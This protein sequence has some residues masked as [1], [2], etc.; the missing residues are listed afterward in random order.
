M[1]LLFHFS[2]GRDTG[3]FLP[4][5]LGQSKP[6]DHN[7]YKGVGKDDAI[8]CPGTNPGAVMDN[9]NDYHPSL[10]LTFEEGLVFYNDSWKCPSL[11]PSESLRQGSANFGLWT[12]CVK[13]LFS[14]GLLV[15][16]GFYVLKWFGKIQRKIILH[17]TW[18]L[19]EIPMC[20]YK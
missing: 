20:V 12:K 10:N 2:P 17:N 13:S 14:Y 15:K 4:C 5:L 18:K 9:T 11:F 1:S 7:D 8:L 19:C 16:N 6:C 3:H